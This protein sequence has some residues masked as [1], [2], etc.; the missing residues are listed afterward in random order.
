[1]DRAIRHLDKS[2]RRL[3]TLDR[4]LNPAAAALARLT[5]NPLQKFEQRPDLL[6]AVMGGTAMRAIR[7]QM[8]GFEKERRYLVPLWDPDFVRRLTGGVN[9]DLMHRAT[10]LREP[11]ALR[12][13]REQVDSAAA[14]R[15]TDH[16]TDLD[17]ALRR[18]DLITSTTAFARDPTAMADEAQRMLSVY[19][20]TLAEQPQFLTEYC[21]NLELFHSTGLTGAM[22]ER[23]DLLARIALPTTLAAGFVGY[24]SVNVERVQAYGES[25]QRELEA[26]FGRD[27]NPVHAWGA[28]AVARRYGID[29]PEWVKD[30]LADVADRI[31]E[32][33]T[34]VADGKPLRREAERVGK[35]LGFGKDRPGGGGRFKRSTILERDRTVY[36][37][38]I[39]W[40][41]EEKARHP[42]QR[43]KLTSAYRE[44]AMAIG[45]DSSTVQRAYAR[46]TKLNSES[47]DQGE[48]NDEVS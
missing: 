12:L 34:E 35:V 18:A 5:P 31:L 46:I 1:M 10:A 47:K 16:W 44:V 36:F 8:D 7:E 3:A 21:A 43:A 11:D 20:P 39:D 15:I 24:N 22:F 4:A 38:V 42:D 25:A 17:R 14:L 9:D 19:G 37:E 6:D 33:R 40:L 27:G 23:A 29:L 41:E 45:V 2:D 28:L 30:Y 48:G 26:D 32:I 13:L